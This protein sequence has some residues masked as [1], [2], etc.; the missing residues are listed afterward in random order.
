MMRWQIQTQS[1]RIRLSKQGLHHLLEEGELREISHISL[2]QLHTRLL[3]LSEAGIL[4]RFH[5]TSDQWIVELPRSLVV[6][7]VAKQP[8][9]EALAFEIPTLTKSPF[10]IEFDIDI[11]DKNR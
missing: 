1:L 11:R 7:F 5:L 8:R 9:R 3:R 4:P 6:E 2:S 10:C